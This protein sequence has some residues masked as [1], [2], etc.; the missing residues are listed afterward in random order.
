MVKMRQ[1]KCKIVIVA[2]IRTP[3][4]KIDGAFSGLSAVDLGMQ[5]MRELLVRS[6]VTPKDIDAVIVGNVIQPVEASNI[7][8]V[9]ALNAGLPRS[10]SAHT[11]HR[12]CASGM[13][14]ITDAAEKIQLGRADVVMA[15]GVESMTHAPLLFHDDVRAAMSR[16]QKARAWQTKIKVLP[17]L[18]KASWKPRVG[19]LEGLTDVTIGM[20]M[21]DTAEVLAREFSLSRI[22][23]DA[24]ALQSHER[25]QAAW[26]SGWFDEEVMHVFSGSAFTP[27]HHDEGIRVGQSMQALAKLRPAFDRSLGSVTAGNSSQL[28]DGAAMLIVSHREKAEAEGW[29]ILGYLH[30]WAYTGCDPKRMGMG[31]VHACHQLLSAR[32]LSMEDMARV[33]INEAFAAQVLA[34][35]DALGSQTFAEKTWGEGKAVGA[36]DSSVLNVHG[37]AIAMGHPVGMTGARLI[38]TLLRQLKHD[39]QGGLGLAS[40]CIGGGQGAAVLLGG[41]AWK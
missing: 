15:G 4:G 6:Q 40:L 18:L 33:E 5:S 27:V 8:R 20:G 17:Q 25:A 37:G 14:A 36:P 11:V 16:L 26:E 41:E 29:S 21:G 28:T 19:L 32:N 23:Q 9:I 34:N 24:W 1:S 31:P 3:L 10:I 2:G 13:Q 35:L 12:N 38:L 7:A 30:D 39:T 22:E